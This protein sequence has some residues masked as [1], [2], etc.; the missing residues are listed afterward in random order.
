MAN[1]KSFYTFTKIGKDSIMDYIEIYTTFCSSEYSIS[2]DNKVW[3]TGLIYTEES[4]VKAI[5][6]TFNY[7]FCKLH[8]I[9]FILQYII[10][11]RK[12]KKH[13]ETGKFPYSMRYHN[14][15][16]PQER[17]MNVWLEMPSKF[18][19][20]EYIKWVPTDTVDNKVIL[21]QSV[22]DYHLLNVTDYEFENKQMSLIHGFFIEDN[23]DIYEMTKLID[24]KA[25]EGDIVLYS[26]IKTLSVNV[27]K[28]KNK[29]QSNEN[30]LFYVLSNSF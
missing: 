7:E 13:H 22:G 8:D 28:M 18:M 3:M 10:T 9:Q 20:Y 25:Q 6:E 12:S 16:T 26:D 14:I 1:N 27:R 2:I 17:E 21:L 19:I 5:K 24:M 15:V 4:H 11:L 30:A 29:W 23:E